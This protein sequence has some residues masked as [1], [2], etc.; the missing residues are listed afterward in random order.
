MK[1]LTGDRLKL[2]TVITEAALEATLIRTIERLGAH[3]Y[4]IVDARGKGAR[5]A[6]DAGWEASGNIRIEVV[7]RSETAA[8]IAAHLQE[9]Y[10]DDYA[11]IVF[12]NEIDV[13]RP[14]KF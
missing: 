11:M 13:F 14:E 10:Y 6:R 4:T 7:C 3:G 8:D 1:P 2:L 5:G 12:V 9:H